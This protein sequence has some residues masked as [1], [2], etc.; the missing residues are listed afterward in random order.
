MNLPLSI[1]L[2][3]GM[4]LKAKIVQGSNCESVV[5]AEGDLESPPPILTTQAGVSQFEDEGDKMRAKGQHLWTYPHQASAKESQIHFFLCAPVP[6][7][8]GLS[9]FLSCGCSKA[10]PYTLM[11]V[12]SHVPV[13]NLCS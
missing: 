3:P 10:R 4:T 12:Y 1:I 2:A 5:E 7:I 8:I 9:A 13:I 6:S 11:F